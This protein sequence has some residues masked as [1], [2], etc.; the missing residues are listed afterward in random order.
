MSRTGSSPTPD[1]KR[2]LDAPLPA[3]IRP[4]LRFRE[5]GARFEG[6]VNHPREIVEMFEPVDVLNGAIELVDQEGV[7]IL[8]GSEDGR[9][10]ETNK[11]PQNRAGL[12]WEI[13]G[14]ALMNGKE[15][16]RNLQQ[17]WEEHLGSPFPPMP[18]GGVELDRWEDLVELDSEVAGIATTILAG[19]TP[20][21]QRL[22]RLRRRL[23]QQYQLET[24]PMS[25]YRSALRLL[26][27]EID[28]DCSR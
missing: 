18:P 24:L 21:R 10:L 26:V 28:R 27:D 7:V 4:P 20:D 3:E 16:V 15:N 2:R 19:G 9:P 1:D 12:Y 22:R 6:E 14:G 11:Y 25:T 8:V 17:L 5:K 13:L 23:S